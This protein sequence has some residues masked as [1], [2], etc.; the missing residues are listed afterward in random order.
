[1]ITNFH[2]NR[3][4]TLSF[5][6]KLPKWRKPQEFITYPMQSGDGCE[7]LRFQSDKRWIECNINTGVCEM[8]NGKGGHPN[9]WLLAFQKIRGQHETFTIS[10]ADLQAI[11]MQVFITAGKMVGGIVLSDNSGAYNII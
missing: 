6:L 9:S 8:T 3:M 5:E 10:E 11:K 2:K 7:L 4:G 1:M